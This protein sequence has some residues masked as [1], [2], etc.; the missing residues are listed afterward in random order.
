MP[1]TVTTIDHPVLTA[2]W[3]AAAGM[4]SAS[5]QTMKECKTSM[6]ALIHVDNTVLSQLEMIDVPAKL[7]PAVTSLRDSLTTLN[8]VQ[9]EIIRKFIEKG[10]VSGFE[11]AGGL[12]S[13]I[14]NAINATKAAS[15]QL[16]L[17]AGPHSLKAATGRSFTPP[18]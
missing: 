14:D 18:A 10:D 6:L 8:E 11:N 12:G 4:K 13:P 3:A 15:F 5:L 1:A 17:L 9:T 2:H 16:Q 7:Q